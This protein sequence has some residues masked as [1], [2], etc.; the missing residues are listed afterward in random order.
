M[1][2]VLAALLLSPAAPN[3]TLAREFRTPPASARP[4][5]YWYFMEGNMTREGMDADL[6]AMR[7]AGIGGAIFLEVDIGIQRGPVRY[8]SPEWLSML[9]YAG[10]KA[11]EKGI[12][13]AIGTGPGWCG[14][15]GPWVRPEEAMQR[16]VSSET[17]VAGPASFH[18]A[19][20]QPKPREPF[21]GL[22][23]L[24]PELRKE[25]ESFYRD[26]AILAVPT[27]EG[28]ARLSDLDEKA[29]VNRAPFSSQADVRPFL[30]PDGRTVPSSQTIP[31]G[32]V[33]DLTNRFHEGKLDWEV[34]PGRWT[35]LR[36]GR[37]L[38][39]S[40]TR[41]APAAGL[42][43]ET[44]K[45]DRPGIEAHLDRFI[46][47]IVE[48][49]GPNRHP[50][51]GL[52]TLHFDSWEMGSQNWSAGF[53][54][55]FRQRRG[56]DPLLYLPVM[57]GK[58]VGSVDVSERFLWDLR[59]TAQELVIQNH[60]GSI[61]ARAKRYGLKVDVEPYDMNPTSDLALGA[62]AD[63]P[64]GE[65]WSKGYGYD[66]E[67][68]VDEA[69]SVAHTNGHAIVG[70]E[71]FTADDRDGWLQHPASMKAQGDWA[72]A[73]GINRFAFHRY[74][75][76]PKPDEF[77]GM[78]MGPYGVHWE[79]TQTWWDMVPAYHAY[80]SRCQAMLQKGVAVAD[81]L[82]LA[83]EGAP[84]VF[85]PPKDAKIGILPDRRG[86]NFDGCAPETLIARASV[87]DGKIVFP[88]G[89]SYRLLVLPRVST[90]T[91]R[92]ARKIESLIAAGA[93][94]IGNPP[95]RSPSLSGYPSCDAEV[96][97]AGRAWKR[98]IPDPF[99]PPQAEARPAIRDASWIWADGEGDPTVAAPVGTRTFE[100]AFDLP[101][102]RVVASAKL[103]AT[104]DN[105]FRLQVNGRTLLTGD[106]FHRIE[107]TEARSA[108]SSGRNRITLAVTNDGTAPNPAGALVTL[109][110]R[111]RDGG[112]LIV[113][114]D[115][116]WQSEG[117]PVKV[118][119]PFD[120]A[121]WSLHNDAPRPELYPSYATAARV[122]ARNL[123]TPPDLEAGEALRYGHRR[124][125]GTDLYFVANRSEKPFNGT[126]T[127]RLSGGQPEWWDPM[128][129]E[130]RLLPAFQS[131]K[132]V[133]K[134]SLDLDGLGSGFVVFRKP[135]Q[136]GT[137]V[138]FPRLER[139]GELK[140]G[141]T[142]QFE[143]RFGGPE[144]PVSFPGLQDWRDR[145]EESVR[146]YSGKAVYRKSF[147]APP[148]ARFLSLGT[149]RNM[150]SVRLNG[151][152]LG[153]AWC[154]PWRLAIPKGTLK[155][156]GNL[157]EITVANLWA[158]RLIGDA[159]LPPERRITKTTWSPYGADSPLLPSGLLGP[160]T[161]MR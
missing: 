65:F 42:G 108:L 84:N 148:D 132:G 123:R 154:A 151:R 61:R 141:W 30:L 6:E 138:N 160:V 14:T 161:L 149:V 58:I 142:V 115:G 35:L 62:T 64:M 146:H 116:T 80:L 118:V 68:S 101:V 133:T 155:A 18:R 134:V 79:R 89:S 122:L 56:Y 96:F 139:V 40:T 145:P 71:A 57:A 49:T 104:A 76:Q 33:M 50:G 73:T 105:R 98:V 88:E 109:D 111:F 135:G 36:F 32:R 44:D 75:H 120:M 37:T 83:P 39:G 41:P 159:G 27:P 31:A 93:T 128:T 119:G 136:S 12:A 102:G 95:K 2:P 140:G 51:R 103:M 117:K 4:W 25:W 48:Q 110:I 10:E 158:N 20:P 72:L 34:P 150:A 114:S 152:D 144:A 9:G 153:V 90:M 85:L 21:F 92:L 106:D 22:G 86:Y 7:K 67:Y 81:I 97:A 131:K 70:A 16:L 126:A 47:A 87:K 127:F 99:S 129:G 8:M 55:A 28:D 130:T 38:A 29:L 45:F 59:Q 107:S 11:N 53:R 94:V 112:R 156:K 26:E 113:R 157:L 13:L 66:S 121:P 5:V 19:L 24:T 54:A 78:T 15:G 82:Y 52:T 137:G 147:D 143:T 60:L 3:D 100:K 91:P 124:W 74:Q 63:V 125:S 1:L 69:V 17:D 43:F 77:P 23:S 46:D